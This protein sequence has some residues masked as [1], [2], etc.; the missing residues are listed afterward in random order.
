MFNYLKDRN[1]SNLDVTLE[2]Y[3]FENQEFKNN[4][5]NTPFVTK[6]KLKVNESVTESAGNLLLVNIGKLIG[7]QNNLYQETERLYDLELNYNKILKHKI[8]FHIPKG[9]VVESYADLVIDKSMNFD[10]AKASFFKSTVKVEDKTVVI[11]IE[12]Q[13][14]SIFYPK[15]SYQ[16][17]RKIINA[18]ADFVKATLVLK[19]QN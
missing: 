4:Y 19:Q 2:S 6:L 17:Y 18:A 3:L 8:V 1:S 16:E 10:K 15:E 14:N 9:Y 13:Y 12:E 5:N 7:K 11:K